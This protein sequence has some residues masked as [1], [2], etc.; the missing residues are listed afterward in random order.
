[1][2]LERRIGDMARN[3]GKKSA[4]DL[5]STDTRSSF[6]DDIIG[7][8]VPQKFKQPQMESYDGSGSPVD[9]VHTY[10]SWM[11]LRQFR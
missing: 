2:D 10:K 5:T 11:A 6:I 4:Y 9:H 1:M 3:M 7:V 8:V